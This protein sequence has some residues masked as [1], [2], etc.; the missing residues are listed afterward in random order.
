[1]W[2]LFEWPQQCGR[3]SDG[4]QLAVVLQWLR[5]VIVDLWQVVSGCCT[6]ALVGSAL[7]KYAAGRAATEGGVEWESTAA[8]REEW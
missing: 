4:W 7:Y 3:G 5:Q 1:M 6:L 2:A 8:D